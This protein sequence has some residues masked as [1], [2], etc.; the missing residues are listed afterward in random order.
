MSLQIISSILTEC[1]NFVGIV[2]KD[3]V[4]LLYLLVQESQHLIVTGRNCM[5]I[6]PN[7]YNKYSSEEE[8]VTEWLTKEEGERYGA[9]LRA[10]IC[11][12]F[13]SRCTALSVDEDISF[14]SCFLR[15]FRLLQYIPMGWVAYKQ[16]RLACHSPDV[17][18]DHDPAVIVICVSGLH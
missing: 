8:A 16:N 18:R 17:W 3:A 11:S 7:H 13:S 4:V 5:G 2:K 9:E 12:M 15:P 10:K 1:H 6:V 14:G